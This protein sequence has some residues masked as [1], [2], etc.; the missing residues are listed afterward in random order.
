MTGKP[1]STLNNITV[2]KETLATPHQQQKQKPEGP[3]SQFAG[4]VCGGFL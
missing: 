4:T 3:G 2:N 1:S